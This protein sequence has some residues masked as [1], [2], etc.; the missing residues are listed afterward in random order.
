MKTRL[1]VLAVAICVTFVAGSKAEERTKLAR[2]GMLLPESEAS[3]AYLKGLYQ[4]LAAQGLLEGNNI[5][6]EIRH[7]NGRIDQLPSLAAELA[8]SGVDLIFTSGDQAGKAAKQ[9]TGRILIVAVTC[10]ALAAGLVTNLRRR[11]AG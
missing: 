6:L 8:G 3:S 5:S 9:A 4:G 10:D 1:L 2:I 7:A 11:P